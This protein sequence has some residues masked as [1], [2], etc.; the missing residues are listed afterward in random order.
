LGWPKRAVLSLQSRWWQGFWKNHWSGWVK[1]RNK[2]KSEKSIVRG[3]Q[4]NSLPFS[5][6][7]FHATC[8][9]RQNVTKPNPCSLL[10]SFH[11]SP[12]VSLAVSCL[13]FLVR[14]ALPSPHCPLRPDWK[15]VLL[16]PFP[17][18]NTAS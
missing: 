10:K 3:V 13:S 7:C 11:T 1:R 2:S 17:W 15:I 5:A 9:C 8:D 12:K 18:I 16:T 14:I 6:L 4:T